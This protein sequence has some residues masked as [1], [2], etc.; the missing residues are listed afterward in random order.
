MHIRRI[1]ASV[2]DGRIT[3]YQAADLSTLLLRPVC[4]RPAS[5]TSAMIG[6]YA[7]R[8]SLPLVVWL[9]CRFIQAATALFFA[10]GFRCSFCLGC[11][12]FRVVFCS[13]WFSLFFRSSPSILLLQRVLTSSVITLRPFA[14]YLSSWRVLLLWKVRE[15]NPRVTTIRRSCLSSR[16]TLL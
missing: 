12:W 9:R 5:C 16:P 2:H 3:V 4:F 14:L 11:R 7:L 6:A 1:L 8:N 10:Y 15:S 13:F